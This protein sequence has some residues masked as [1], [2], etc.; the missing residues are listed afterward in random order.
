[1]VNGQEKVKDLFCKKK[2][3]G[4]PHAQGQEPIDDFFIW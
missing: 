1:M 4:L 3:R 2:V